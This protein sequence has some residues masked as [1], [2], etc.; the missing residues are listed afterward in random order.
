M[1]QKNAD[2]ETLKQSRIR[3][4]QKAVKTLRK[5]EKQRLRD[6]YNMSSAQHQCSVFRVFPLAH[7]FDNYLKLHQPT[8]EVIE[9]MIQAADYGRLELVHHT[10]DLALMRSA[11]HA[12]TN[13]KRRQIN[14]D[15]AKNH[16]D[17][18]NWVERAR[19]FEN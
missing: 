6:P 19:Y 18:E 13:R 5:M 16:M 14:L 9:L 8:T 3:D 11:I 4:I 1:F 10:R 15:I 17:F 12:T 2:D 7:L